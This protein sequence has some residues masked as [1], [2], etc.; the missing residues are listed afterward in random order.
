[1][2]LLT[3]IGNLNLHTYGLNI[4]TQTDPLLNMTICFART[5]DTMLCIGLIH[6][7]L[8]TQLPGPTMWTTD[9]S[10]SKSRIAPDAQIIVVYANPLIPKALHRLTA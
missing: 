5:P 4:P 9:L 8:I 7:L 10:P 6:T 1:M 2:K 3:Q